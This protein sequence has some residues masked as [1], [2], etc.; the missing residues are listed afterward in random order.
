[1]FDTFRN[2]LNCVLDRDPAARGK[3]E[4]YFCYPGFRAIRMHRFANRLYRHGLRF[5][6]RIVSEWTR[7]FTGIEIHPAV[8]IGQRL[9][10]DHG[11]GVVIG[12]TAKIGDDVTLYQGVTLGGTGKDSGKRHPTLGDHVTVGAG[13]TILGPFKVG[14]HS[15]IGA[16]AVVLSE[17]PPHATIVG[18]PGHVVRANA[19]CKDCTVCLGERCERIA[20]IGGEAGVDLDHI[21]MPDPVAAE[22][23][24]MRQRLDALEKA[25][26]NSQC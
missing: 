16:G 14:D 15:K 2:D 24:A 23:T 21:H 3:W 4:V 22:L 17:V 7:F 12:E 25:V 19:A 26:K 20:N 11:A 8:Q 1:M 13:A 18:V 6:A 9:F 5:F 10:I